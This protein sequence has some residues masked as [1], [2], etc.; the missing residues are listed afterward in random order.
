VEAFVDPLPLQRHVDGGVVGDAL[1]GSESTLDVLGEIEAVGLTF[2]GVKCR[3]EGLTRLI[4][5]SGFPVNFPQSEE[6]LH[7]RVRNRSPITARCR[8][9]PDDLLVEFSSFLG[10][11][12]FFPNP[13]KVMHGSQ[14]VWVVDSKDIAADSKHLLMQICGPSDITLLKE[15]CG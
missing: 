4:E 7:F 15:S 8:S 1:V 13:G 10:I 5:S 14:G 9:Q 11:A 2:E 12:R 6:G 3:V